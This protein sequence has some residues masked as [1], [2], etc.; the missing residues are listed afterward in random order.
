M[1]EQRKPVQIL[2]SVA[3]NLGQLTNGFCVSLSSFALPQILKGEGG[4]QMTLEESSWFASMLALGCITGALLGG[5]TCDKLGRRKS[6]ML[7]CIGYITGFLLIGLAPS[8][9]LLLLGRFLTGHFAGSNLVCTPIFVG[10]TSHPSIRGLTGCMLI[11]LYCSGFTLS[12]FL[13]AV[14]PWRTVI[15]LAAVPAAISFVLLYL[16]KESPTWLLRQKREAEAYE[17][18][19]FYRGSELVVR[20]ELDRIK[21]NL[22]RTEK[23]EEATKTTALENIKTK[24]KRIVDPSFLKPFL[25][26]NL[27]LN[28]GLEWGGFPALAFYMHTILEEVKV[29]FDT[30]WIAVMLSAFRTVVSIGLSFILVKVPRRP[31]YLFA[32][33]LVAIALAIQAG[34]AW[35]SPLV[36]EEYKSVARWIPV[37]AIIVQYLGFGLG[38]GVIMYN[39][40]GEILPSDM[41]SFGSGL[42]G[43]I[44]NISLFLSVKMV[45]VLMSS[46]G[47][48]GMFFTYCCFTL[49]TVT[50]CFFVMPETKGMSLEEI[51]DFYASMKKTKPETEKCSSEV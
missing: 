49:L 13:G 17:A 8:F 32:G 6:M 1:W 25:L 33:S 27:M 39:L 14:F 44:D 15:L 5:Y 47:V 42:L 9:P 10:E 46:I 21:E 35:L 50:I 11:I 48:G 34:F 30:Y 23:H 22:R 4:V 26:L 18:L 51:E 43:I 12:M 2:A 38:Y 36:P 41:R 28:V 37:L 45:P 3:A 31:M 16:V 20:E 29:P 19:F 40:Q 7:D 24:M